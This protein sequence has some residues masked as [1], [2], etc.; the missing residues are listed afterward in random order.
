MWPSTLK[1]RPNP[2]CASA[3]PHSAFWRAA[4]Y[5]DFRAIA[6]N[7]RE[8]QKFFMSH[9]G[10]FP[11]KDKNLLKTGLM[12]GNL[13]KSGKKRSVAFHFEGSKVDV[14]LGNMSVSSLVDL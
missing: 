10:R 4:P 2:N 13:R 12:G 8:S 9:D 1:R 14:L 6:G 5:A 7:K 11:L 3:S